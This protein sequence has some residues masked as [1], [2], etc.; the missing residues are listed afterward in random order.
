MVEDVPEG[1]AETIG[2]IA[3]GFVFFAVYYLLPAWLLYLLLCRESRVIFTPEYRA[4]VAR[5]PHIR[6]KTSRTTKIVVA[7]T[8]AALIALAVVVGVMSS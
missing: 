1:V 8:V 3:A 5:T 2:A 7:L 6:Y 4:V